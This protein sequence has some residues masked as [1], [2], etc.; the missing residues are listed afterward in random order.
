MVKGSTGRPESEKTLPVSVSPVMV[1][2]VPTALKVPV[3]DELVVL[4][5]TD[6]KI[7]LA[8]LRVRPAPVPESVAGDGVFDAFLVN[9]RLPETP[10]GAN[11]P[12][13]RLKVEL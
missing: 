3:W 5:G 12:K 11:G 8:G 7:R 9:D 13:P 6:P 10:P 1:T 2:L 4:S